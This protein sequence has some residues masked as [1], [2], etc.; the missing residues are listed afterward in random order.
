MDS[1]MPR[2]FDS[3]RNGGIPISA[4]CKLLDET[5]KMSEDLRDKATK[6]LSVLPISM[7]AGD[8]GM[9]KKLCL[10]IMKNAKQTTVIGSA[11]VLGSALNRVLHV[12]EAFST[13]L[14][15]DEDL[16]EA[17]LSC[18]MKAQLCGEGSSALSKSLEVLCRDNA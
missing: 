13:A 18:R 15:G 16:I 10:F 1:T 8:E 5:E 3:T 4:A 14:H 17:L 12:L 2:R 11:S 7:S 6:A 9:G